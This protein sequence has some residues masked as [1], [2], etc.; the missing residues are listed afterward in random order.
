MGRRLSDVCQALKLQ[1]HTVLVVVVSNVF[2]KKAAIREYLSGPW[3]G[4]LGKDF[5]LGVGVL[6]VVSYCTC[7]LGHHHC[8]APIR[9]PT[10][11]R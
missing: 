1:Y 3:G 7:M 6:P 10:L 2:A 8:T 4:L 9:S 11:L 5:C